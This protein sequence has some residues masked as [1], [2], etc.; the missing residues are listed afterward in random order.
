MIVSPG[1]HPVLHPVTGITQQ[2]RHPIVDPARHFFM[3][4][5]FHKHL[6]LAFANALLNLMQ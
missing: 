2:V 5:G 3:H 4:A 1:Y 6:Q